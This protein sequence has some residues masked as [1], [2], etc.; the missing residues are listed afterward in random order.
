MSKLQR[1]RAAASKA[2][3]EAM[4]D[5]NMQG[6]ATVF[7]G[8]IAPALD[9]RAGTVGGLEAA[10]ILGIGSVV[11]A[12]FGPRKM[13]AAAMGFGSGLL[14]VQSSEVTSLLVEGASLGQLLKP[15]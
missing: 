6:A 11:L 4:T 8:A 9:K 5:V 13:R 3:K 10:T 15:D 7:G 14:A 1:A 12:V 2:R